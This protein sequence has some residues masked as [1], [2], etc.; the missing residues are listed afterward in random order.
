MKHALINCAIRKEKTTRNLCGDPGHI[1]KFCPRRNEDLDNSTKKRKVS[2]ALEKQVNNTNSKPSSPA[3]T[4]TASRFIAATNAKATVEAQ[5]NSE[6]LAAEQL[7]ADKATAA[8]DK[9]DADTAAANANQGCYNTRSS[10]VNA[11]PTD[12][13]RPLV[14][15]CKHCKGTDYKII[16]SLKCKRNP[17]SPNYIPDEKWYPLLKTLAATDTTDPTDPTKSSDNMETEDESEL[18]DD[19]KPAPMQV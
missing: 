16:S 10:N 7:A 13:L 12:L 5:A 4:P 11:P 1:K 14:K 6:Q 17:N 19:D 18:A 8:A 2:K 9:L 3:K 15:L